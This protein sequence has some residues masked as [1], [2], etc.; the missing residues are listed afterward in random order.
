M[1]SIWSEAYRLA[2]RVFLGVFDVGKVC[3]PVVLLFIA[4]HG[5]HLGHGMVYV[6]D[7]AVPTRV[8]GACREFVYIHKFVDGRCTLCAELES[9]V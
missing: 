9:V 3:I 1:D 4:D 6:F 8:V 5:Q 2:N 7:A